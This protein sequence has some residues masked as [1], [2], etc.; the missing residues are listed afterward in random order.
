MRHQTSDGFQF[1][2]GKEICQNVGV[3]VLN[4]TGIR[5]PSALSRDERVIRALARSRVVSLTISSFVSASNGRG[6]STIAP[7]MLTATVWADALIFSPEIVTSS[8]TGTRR[9]TRWL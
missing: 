5:Y 8:V 3:W 6:H 9:M 1:A 4:S 2:G 7:W